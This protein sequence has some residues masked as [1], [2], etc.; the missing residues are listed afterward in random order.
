MRE[1][2]RVRLVRLQLLQK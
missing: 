2:F 1:T